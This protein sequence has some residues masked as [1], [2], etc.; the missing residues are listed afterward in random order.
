MCGLT[1]SGQL[2]TRQANE[3]ILNGIT[4]VLFSVLPQ[5]ASWRSLNGHLRS[6]R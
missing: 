1:E 6:Q 3:A 4:V 2:I 5:N